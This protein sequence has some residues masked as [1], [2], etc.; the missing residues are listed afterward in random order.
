MTKAER[1]A[2]LADVHVGVIGIAQDE[3][4]PLTVPIWYS[5]EPGGTVNVIISPSSLK[6]RAIDVAGR[7]TLCAQTEAAPYQYVSVEGPAV[8]E[9]VDANERRAMAHRYLGPELGDLYVAGTQDD[10]KDN[11]VVRMTP[12]RWRTTDYNKQFA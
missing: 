3:Q 9:P 7:F 12:E 10:A 5:Y 2:F 11:I 8:A 6:A 4:G 1:E